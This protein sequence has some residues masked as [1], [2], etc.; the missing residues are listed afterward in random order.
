M[1]HIDGL[2]LRKACG[3]FATGVTIITTEV[4]GDI[5]GMTANA[6][7]SVS[8][9]PPLVLIAVDNRAKMNQLLPQ[10]GRYAV[11]ILDEQQRQP[12]DHFA[13]RVVVGLDMPFVRFHSQPVI[14]GALAWFVATIQ[15]QMAAG[16]HTLYLG[17]VDHLAYEDGIPLIFFGGH[18]LQ[19]R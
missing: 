9:E 18:Y 12:S 3:R 19:N 11:S 17:Q 4:D 8:L 14:D 2:A 1:S 15:E 5:H 6:F 16:D 13:G 7:M 10:S